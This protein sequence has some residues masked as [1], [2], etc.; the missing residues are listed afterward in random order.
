MEKSKEF[1]NEFCLKTALPQR[2]KTAFFR[3]LKRSLYFD[4]LRIAFLSVAN[5]KSVNAAFKAAEGG[6]GERGGKAKLTAYCLKIYRAAIKDGLAVNRALAAVLP[7]LDKSQVLR[8]KKRYF[9][10]VCFFKSHAVSILSEVT[11]LYCEKRAERR[12][13]NEPCVFDKERFVR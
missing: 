9:H 5:G 2:L 3:E 11:P 1:K 6:K 8:L 7:S 10:T 13:L 12:A 4:V